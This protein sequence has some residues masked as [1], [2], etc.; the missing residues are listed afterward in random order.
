MAS[1][2]PS[3]GAR[4]LRAVIRAPQQRSLF[5]FGDGFGGCRAVRSIDTRRGDL[6]LSYESV[7]AGAIARRLPSYE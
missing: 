6:I 1:M 5:I 7:L 2:S 3:R 4:T